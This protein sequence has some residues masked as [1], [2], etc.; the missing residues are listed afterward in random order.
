[1]GCAGV[2][3]TVAAGLGLLTLALASFVAPRGSTETSR[4]ASYTRHKLFELASL[5]DLVVAGTIV[6]LRGETF[7]VEVERWLVGE[8]REEPLEVRRFVNWTCAG[9]WTE[10]A[11]GQHVVLFLDEPE[12]AG[13][14]LRI[15]GGGGEGEMPWSEERV[16]LRRFR[17]HG[18]DEGQHTIDGA[19]VFGT[20]VSLDELQAALRGFRP[21]VSWGVPKAKG[22]WFT[23]QVFSTADAEDLA[24]YSA[25]SALAKHLVEELR[26]CER[27]RD[28]QDPPRPESTGVVKRLVTHLPRIPKA[29][30]APAA[31][32]SLPR[33]K[34]SAAL[35]A[36]CAFLG[37][38]DGDGRGDWAVTGIE[39]RD[40]GA[41]Q[42]TAWVLFLDEAGALGHA[43]DVVSGHV[44]L[45]SAIGEQTGDV[46]ALASLGDL[47]RDGVPDLLIGA[48]RWP[49]AKSGQGGVWICFLKRDGSVREAVELG[50]QLEL[51]PPK[52][53]YP[54]Q[55]GGVLASLGD[56]DG[57]GSPEV[58][59][60]WSRRWSPLLRGAPTV[61]A[62]WIVS[63]EPDGTVRWSKRLDGQADGF[64]ESSYW[65]GAL[66]GIGD[67]DGNGVPD[68]AIGHTMDDDGGLYR[69]A[70][71]IAFLKADGGL[72]GK[73][74]ISDWQGEF[75]G[76]LRDNDK[77]GS[78]LCG[79]GDLD[80]DG[81]VDLVVG[82]REGT[83]TLFLRANG[84]VREGLPL[85]ALGGG[86]LSRA[87]FGRSIA[88]G[89]ARDEDGRLMMLSGGDLGE[90]PAVWLLEL[91][92]DGVVSPW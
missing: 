16:V 55:L 40:F 57:D 15:R 65:G 76:L 83:W 21:H 77:F 34:R 41:E 90:E 62:V 11:I 53:R 66:A 24:R 42:G 19:G 87:T 14:P 8:A 44:P 89:G 13:V 50:Q 49:A 64:T 81:V 17:V 51:A 71:L 22:A 36:A 23:A 29:T 58:A 82:T 5:A 28:L 75:D 31:R 73:Q 9:R 85:G 80:G 20:A 3:S 33:P 59:L 12:A 67:V 79:P 69:G 18:M 43:V 60:R 84:T 10:Y 7:E 6:E 35:A 2:R 48:P 4:P 88:V 37:D 30:S 47:D 52:G 25:S 54:V 38:V 56:L 63:L 61:N 45:S 86:F 74:K 78:G 1:M 72:L 26:S 92:S 46:A 91:G 32:T 27:Y 68:L 39:E 70:V